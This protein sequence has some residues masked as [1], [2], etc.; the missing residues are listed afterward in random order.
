MNAVILYN[1]MLKLFKINQLKTA[2]PD[3]DFAKL[4][5]LK[6]QLKGSRILLAE[7]NL[8][9][10]EIAKAVLDGAGINVDISNNGEEA[11]AAVQNKHYSA[12]LMDMQM[13]KMDAY[14]ATRTIRRNPKFKSLP[15]IAMTVNTLKGDKEKYL[16]AGMDNYITKPINQDLLFKMLS[17]FV[18]SDIPEDI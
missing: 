11:V 10:Q 1:A 18:L 13:P 12:V 9:N 5:S 15:I 8:T 2:I 6:K 3:K 16:Q 7:D 4:S 14:E 17:K